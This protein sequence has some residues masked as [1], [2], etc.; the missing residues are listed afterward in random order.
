MCIICKCVKTNDYT[1]LK[2]LKKLDCRWCWKIEYIPFIEG[3]EEL[4]CTGCH[5]L[6]DIAQIDTLINLNCSNCDNL[7][8][9]PYIEGLKILKYDNCPK[10]GRI[11]EFK[12]LYSD[13]QL[14]CLQQQNYGT[15]I[16]KYSQL[17]EKFSSEKFSTEPKSV[18]DEDKLKFVTAHELYLKRL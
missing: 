18:I 14:F 10:I 9:I 2:G 13:V 17:R 15:M 11:P 16:T 8:Y 3:L 6:E 7:R 4:D 1:K 12:N 5:R